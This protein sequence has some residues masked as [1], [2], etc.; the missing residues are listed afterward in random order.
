MAVLANNMNPSDHAVGLVAVSSW[1][2]WLRHTPRQGEF[3]QPGFGVSN[4][5]RL[6]STF[7]WS[8][9]KSAFGYTKNGHTAMLVREAGQITHVVGFNPDSFLLAGLLQ[10]IQGNNIVVQGLWYDDMPMIND[11]TA[12]SYEIN[13]TQPQA[14]DFGA[15][16]GSL[17]GRSDLG[18]HSPNTNHYY[19]FRPAVTEA[20]T[21][22][23]VGNCGNMALMILCQFLQETGHR[24]YVEMLVDW[25]NQNQN[26]R[27]FGQ[28]PLMG[29][30]TSGF[31]R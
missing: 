22:G 23:I 11:P 17:V 18:Q 9:P 12:I 27:N 8:S 21:S 19:S 13:V 15:L 6:W 31:G 14:H 1:Q 5:T 25:V 4:L 28:G 24:N 26:T 2:G 10:T 3:E 30:I 16:I 7:S 29:S 20:Y